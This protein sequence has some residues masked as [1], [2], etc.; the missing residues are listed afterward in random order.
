MPQMVIANNLGDGRVVFLAENDSWV[1]SIADGEL[2]D[3]EKSAEQLLARA[4]RAEA[5]N[6]VIDP[7]LIDVE[8]TDGERRPSHYREYIRAHGPTV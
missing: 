2:V 1:H 8:E 6:K 3:D 4:Q 7:N 5:L